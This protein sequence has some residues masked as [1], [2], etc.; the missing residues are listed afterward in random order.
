VEDDTPETLGARILEVEHRL[1]PRAVRILLEG[2]Y[3]I[4]GRRVILENP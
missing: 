4:V 3:R 1:Y 2:R